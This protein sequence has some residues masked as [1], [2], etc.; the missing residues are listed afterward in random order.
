MWSSLG[1]K[2]AS[3]Q[4]CRPVRS[5]CRCDRPVSR[6]SAD[7]VLYD[8]WSGI[9]D[10]GITVN[11][12][13][14]SYS[15]YPIGP[16]AAQITISPAAPYSLL[17]WCIDFTHN[18]GV[19]GTFTD[20]T[21]VPL[22]PAGLQTVAGMLNSPQ[23]SGLLTSGNGGRPN[24]PLINEVNYL[25]DPGNTLLELE[26][27]RPPPM[28]SGPAS[29]LRSGQSCI[30]RYRTHGA[31]ADVVNDVNSFLTTRLLTTAQSGVRKRSSAPTE[32]SS[33]RMVWTLCRRRN[34]GRL[35]RWLAD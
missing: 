10:N 16:Q 9:G 22:T 30:R 24:Q 4:V 35:R 13:G 29:R 25:M 2:K 12:G 8:N 31:S 32:N 20:Y 6:A 28:T 34:P 17:A 23:P 11:A 1:K 19:P 7:T 27:V 15:G 18:I 14:E 5:Q 33:S 3:E 21:L 26:R